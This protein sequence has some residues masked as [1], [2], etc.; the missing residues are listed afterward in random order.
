[1]SRPIWTPWR[2]IDFYGVSRNSRNGRNSGDILTLCAS[3]RKTVSSHET[4]QLFYFHWSRKNVQRSIFQKQQI[5]VS[6]IAFRARNVCETFQKQAPFIVFVIQNGGP[7]YVE[8]IFSETLCRDSPMW[9]LVP[10]VRGS[11]GRLSLTASPLVAVKAFPWSAYSL[12]P[13]AWES[14]GRGAPKGWSLPLSTSLLCG[15]FPGVS[16]AAEPRFTSALQLT[17]SLALLSQPFPEF[18]LRE[19]VAS[20]DP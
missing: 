8:L 19:A 13:W 2:F 6:W 14:L 7:Y 12:T 4:L 5:T 10:Q 9:W 20:A 15:L 16:N 17:L 11:M 3:K 18:R 1:M